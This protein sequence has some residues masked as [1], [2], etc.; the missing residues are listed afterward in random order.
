MLP[1]L[2]GPRRPQDRVALKDAKSAFLRDRQAMEEERNVASQGSTEIEID[3]RKCTLADGSVV[4]AA[5]TSCT[6]TSN[7]GVMLGAGLVARKAVQRGSGSQAL[8]QGHHLRRVHELSPEYLENAG[9]MKDLEKLGFHNVGYGCTTCIGNSGPLPEP[10]ANAIQDCNLFTAS[11]LS[12]NRNFEGRVHAL[13]RMNYLASPP[14]V[15]VY[16]IAGRMDVDLYNEPLATDPEGNPVFLKEIWPSQQEITHAVRDF[17]STEQY[18]RGLRRHLQR[19][20]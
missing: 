20:K 12:G 7:P 18:L 1:S 4:I 17:L 8:G 6:N 11:V 2:A 14:L 9:V 15:V 13:V 3:D 16:A 19:R 10:V 5:I